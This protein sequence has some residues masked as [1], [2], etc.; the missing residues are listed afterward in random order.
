MDS[1]GE[2]LSDREDYFILIMFIITSTVI[3]NVILSFIGF[4]IVFNSLMTCP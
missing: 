2:V 3:I 4:I 1:D